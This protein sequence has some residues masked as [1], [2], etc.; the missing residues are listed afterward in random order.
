MMFKFF[1]DLFF[2]VLRKWYMFLLEI[3]IYDGDVR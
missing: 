3:W 2:I 1:Y